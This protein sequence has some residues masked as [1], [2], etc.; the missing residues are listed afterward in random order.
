MRKLIYVALLAVVSFGCEPHV[1]YL[2]V[3]P[4]SVVCGTKVTISWRISVGVGEMSADQPVTPSLS[5]P[6]PVNNQGSIDVTVIQTTT[7]KLSLPYGGEQTATVTV[8]Q[9]CPKPTCNPQTVTLTG[10]CFS[11]NQ[12]PTY[13]TQNVNV[14]VAPGN[15]ADLQSDANFP[16]HVLHAGADIALNAG[17]G[18]V[19]PPLPAVPAAGDYTIIVP[20]QVGL[21]VCADASGPVGGGQ[22]DAPTVHLKV[23]GTCPP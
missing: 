15:L 5:P 7:F 3:Q 8:T 9:P 23:T 20:G 14:N 18:P 17:V 2:N 10:T 22:A 21:K 4:S 13:T 1:K 6:K 12:A 19:F 16:V 11:S